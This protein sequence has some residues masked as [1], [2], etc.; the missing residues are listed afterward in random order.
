MAGFTLT[1]RQRLRRE[2]ETLCERDD[3]THPPGLRPFTQT[4]HLLPL[5]LPPARRI[6]ARLIPGTRT[7]ERVS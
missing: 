7:L 4:L 2:P 1:E 6:H 3:A 5:G